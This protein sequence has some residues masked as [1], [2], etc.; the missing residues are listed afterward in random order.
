[1]ARYDRFDAG[2]PEVYRG[3]P[4]AVGLSYD[5]AKRR[6]RARAVA[7]YALQGKFIADNIGGFFLNLAPPYWAGEEVYRSRSSKVNIFSV[8]NYETPRS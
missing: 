3:F 4:E 2:F 6:G 8:I 5:V 1:M 7:A